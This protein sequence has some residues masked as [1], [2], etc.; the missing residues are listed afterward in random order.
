VVKVVTKFLAQYD[1]SV[2][3]SCIYITSLPK[4]PET[5]VS[6]FKLCCKAWSL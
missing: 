5:T 6:K 1:I 4:L 3:H 2:G